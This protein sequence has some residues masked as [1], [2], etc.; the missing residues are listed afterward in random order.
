MLL[1]T[2]PPEACD[3]EPNKEDAVDSAALLTVAFRSISF[4]AD[5]E[6]SP[7]AVTAASRM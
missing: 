7:P 2:T 6:T 3:V 5:S 1:A 4:N